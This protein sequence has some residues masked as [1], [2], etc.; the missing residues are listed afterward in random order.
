VV[1]DFKIPGFVIATLEDAL[2]I[3]AG[4]FIVSRF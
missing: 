4:I 3:G 1:T 2:A